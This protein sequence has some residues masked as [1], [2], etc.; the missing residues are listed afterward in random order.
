MVS[1]TWSQLFALFLSISS[2]GHSPYL[3]YFHLVTSQTKELRASTKRKQP[4]FGSI[5][6]EEL[7][8]LFGKSETESSSSSIRKLN[9]SC[10]SSLSDEN[11]ISGELEMSA[12]L[13][14]GLFCSV[15]RFKFTND[16]TNIWVLTWSR[17]SCL[18]SPFLPP[19]LLSSHSPLFT[20]SNYTSK[21][22]PKEPVE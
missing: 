19:L 14:N 6:A 12:L 3:M 21:M 9:I 16:I 11:T 18:L 4:S 13:G 15:F 22:Y 5:V 8:S 2:L 17:F 1:F 7:D 10:A 20:L